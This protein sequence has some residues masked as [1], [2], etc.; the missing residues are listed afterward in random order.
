[1]RYAIPVGPEGGHS[2]DVFSLMPQLLAQ[3]QAVRDLSASNTVIIVG[4][5]RPAA[6]CPIG[7]GGKAE[8]AEGPRRPLAL[9]DDGTPF[10]GARPGHAPPRAQDNKPRALP[11]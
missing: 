7:R 6:S 5:W 9:D 3:A 4:A 10:L 11:A 1:M 8:G 2:D